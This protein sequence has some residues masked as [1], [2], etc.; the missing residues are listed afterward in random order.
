[1]R[2]DAGDVVELAET[3]R[4]RVVEGKGVGH[5]GGGAIKEKLAGAD[6]LVIGRGAA[7]AVTRTGRRVDLTLA[8][9]ELSRRH[10]RVVHGPGGWELSDLGSKNGTFVGGVPASRVTL[11]DG[12]VVE[13]GATLLVFRE[14]GAPGGDRGDRDLIGDASPAAFRTVSLGL[15]RQLADLGRIAPSTVPVLVR[16]ETG[17]GKELIARAVHELSGRRGGFVPVNCGALPRA[18][19]ESELFGY[20]RGAFSGARDD[21][22]GLVRRADGGT[23]FLDE[24]AELPEESQVALLRVLQEGEVRPI[25]AADA[26]RVDVRVVAA[27]HQDLPARIVAGRFREDLYARLAGFQVALPPLRDRREDVGALV[28]AILPRLDD[29]GVV[30]FHR[31]AARALLAYPYPLNV[32]E[33]EQ[34]LR[35]AVVL[36]GGREVRLEHL[37]E[38]IRDHV[39]VAA[40][41]ALRPED[42]ALRE[43]LIEL[44]RASHGNVAAAG[45]ALGK[46]PVQIRR[47]CRRFDIDLASFRG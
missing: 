18:L 27:T 24:I 30:T 33:L 22:E 44:L 32:R 36:A 47:W 2:S 38:A 4:K 14:E 1:S 42:R 21:R 10:A 39:P 20:R 3:D 6:E 26:L 28:A 12:D 40:D 46:A 43:R 9:H 29:A 5:G 16:G 13:L 23:L 11:G 15:E 19:I 31:A 17:T 7:R 25:G 34:A 37:P 8:D 35:A 45:R 41:D